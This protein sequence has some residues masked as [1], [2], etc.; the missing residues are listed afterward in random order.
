MHT[1]GSI[2]GVFQCLDFRDPI[3]RFLIFITFNLYNF[4][5]ATIIPA[6]KAGQTKHCKRV[7][8]KG[9][10]LGTVDKSMASKHFVACITS[11]HRGALQQEMHCHENPHIS[12]VLHGG[13][14]EKRKMSQIERPVGKMTFYHA[15][16]YHQSIYT[17]DSSR[18]I[19]VEVE[20]G[21]F[22]EYAI[23]EEMFSRAISRVPDAKFLLLRIYKELMADDPMSSV[24]IDMLLLELMDQLLQFQEGD[25]RPAWLRNIEELLR[26]QRL[27]TI[28]LSVLS[29][30]VQ[31]HPVTISK[32]FH[33]Y[34]GC[35]LGEYVRKLRVERSL[36]LIKDPDRSLTDISYECGFADQSHFIRTFKRLTGLLPHACRNC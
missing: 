25:K 23:V 35:T 18:H 30:M 31:V 14:L 16:E 20:N 36:S 27:E 21:F 5:K 8:E 32:Q 33:R 12:Y 15:G 7:L 6:E 19:N 34:Y 11:Y 9:K 13:N 28:S 4:K 1:L 29:G 2:I 26:D 17:I 22:Q 3:S 10:Y 24:S